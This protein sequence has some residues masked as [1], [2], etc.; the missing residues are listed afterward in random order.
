[1]ERGASQ[2]SWH[3]ISCHLN[4]AHMKCSPTILM[5]DHNHING[6][7]EGS[8]IDGVPCLGDR[9]TDAPHVLHASE[10]K[11]PTEPRDERKGKPL[12]P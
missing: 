4:H 6:S 7:A 5:F 9:A 8:R 1:M 3:T 2:S 11:A 10:D 12:E